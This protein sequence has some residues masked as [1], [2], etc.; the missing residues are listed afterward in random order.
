MEKAAAE[1]AGQELR[2]LAICAAQTGRQSSFGPDAPAI[3]PGVIGNMDR[4]GHPSFNEWV[5][6]SLSPGVGRPGT[7]VYRLYMHESRRAARAGIPGPQMGTRPEPLPLAS[8][9]IISACPTK[10]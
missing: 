4:I 10:G 1:K 8:G 7:S 9:F 6:N 3:L 2:K 5:T